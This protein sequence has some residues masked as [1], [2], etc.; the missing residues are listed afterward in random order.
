MHVFNHNPIVVLGFITSVSL[1]CTH[2]TLQVFLLWINLL[3]NEYRASSVLNLGLFSLCGVTSTSS[4]ISQVQASHLASCWTS[5]SIWT[6]SGPASSLQW[7]G[8]GQK[9]PFLDMML[10]RGED[11][12]THLSTGRILTLTG[13]SH[14][15]TMAVW[16]D[17]WSDAWETEPKEFLTQSS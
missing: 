3:H 14:R 1:R 9:L 15:T 17:G 13:T 6:Q 12:L 2:I 16:S 4:G 7:T 5:L 11:R 8:G 10:T